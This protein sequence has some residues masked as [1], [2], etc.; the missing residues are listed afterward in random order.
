M[1]IGLWGSNPFKTTENQ[2]GNLIGGAVRGNRMR[3]W[4]DLEPACGGRTPVRSEYVDQEASQG[5]RQKRDH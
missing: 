3:P 2:G 5:K 1:L 4:D